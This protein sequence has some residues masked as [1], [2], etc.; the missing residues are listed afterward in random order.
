MT[1]SPDRT[2]RSP[3]NSRRDP[4]QAS[5]LEKIPSQTCIKRGVEKKAERDIA[6]SGTLSPFCSTPGGGK[7]LRATATEERRLPGG[8]GEKGGGQGDHGDKKQVPEKRKAI[9]EGLTPTRR[10]RTG[11]QNSRQERCG[12]DATPN[13]QCGRNQVEREATKNL[14]RCPS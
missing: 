12:R 11:A 1:S 5:S 9:G 4:D 2:A 8:G 3:G 10:D 13:R 7:A 14:E 6:G